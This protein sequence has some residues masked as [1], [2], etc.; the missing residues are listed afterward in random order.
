MD[1]DTSRGRDFQCIAQ[2]VYCCDGLPDYL[3]PTAQKLEKWLVRVDAPTEGFMARVDK[4]L[5]EFW[6]L[7]S[8]KHLDKGLK[9][10]EKRVAPVEFV[11]IG[12]PTRSLFSLW[13]VLNDVGRPQVYSSTSCAT[14][15]TKTAPKQSTI[16]VRTSGTNSKTCGTTRT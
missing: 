7:A 3:L 10:F 4:A 9:K 8:T 12:A 14:I 13:Y 11:F 1:W 15:H 2:M 16:C 5:T 6:Y